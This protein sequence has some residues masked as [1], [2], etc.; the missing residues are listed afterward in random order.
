MPDLSS[1]YHALPTLRGGV[2]IVQTVEKGVDT[3]L[4]TDLIRLAVSNTYDVAVIASLD[5]DM[6]PAVEFVQTLSKK[7]IQAG[8]PPMGT[9]LATECWGSFDI[10]SIA[11]KIER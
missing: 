11:D 1:R 10:M 4:V 6:I 5:A 2:P 8:F 3:L 7:I 9:A